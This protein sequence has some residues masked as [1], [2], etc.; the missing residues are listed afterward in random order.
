MCFTG[1][2]K[3]QEKANSDNHCDKYATL[4]NGYPCAGP[5]EC[6]SICTLRPFSGFLVLVF[7]YIRKVLHSRKE[8][9]QP[10]LSSTEC[11]RMASYCRNQ[12]LQV[13]KETGYF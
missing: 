7:T 6:R 3:G 12:R 11:K 9:V 1:A 8:R 13:K 10:L 5:Q 4:N 2:G